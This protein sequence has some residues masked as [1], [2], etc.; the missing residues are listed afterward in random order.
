MVIEQ[1][2][3]TVQSVI[4]DDRMVTRVLPTWVRVETT[5]GSFSILEWLQHERDRFAQSGIACEIVKIAKSGR[6]GL[7]RKA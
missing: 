6:V 4:T 7:R 1:E 2:V 3:T 5:R